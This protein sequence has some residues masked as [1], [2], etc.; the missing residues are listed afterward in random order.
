MGRVLMT[1]W[2]ILLILDTARLLLLV[3]RRAVVAALAG[4]TLQRDLI[5]Q[6]NDLRSNFTV[7]LLG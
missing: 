6:G 4:S 3:L 7:R 2:T 5:S 1:P